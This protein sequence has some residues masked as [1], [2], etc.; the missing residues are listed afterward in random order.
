MHLM[1]RK[2]GLFVSSLDF[3]FTKLRKRKLVEITPN[4]SSQDYLIGNSMKNVV[5]LFSWDSK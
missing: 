3:C 5:P 2:I 1:R 4:L